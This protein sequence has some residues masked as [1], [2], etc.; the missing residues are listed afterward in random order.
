MVHS[1]ELSYPL[2]GPFPPSSQ[3]PT[4]AA[5]F[6]MDICCES[7]RSE[8]PRSVFREVAGKGTKISSQ[9]PG[10]SLC[11]LAKNTDSHQKNIQSGK[12]LSL[13]SPFRADSGAFN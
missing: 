6:I 8:P 7:H 12:K 9:L 11:Q 10:I 4:I 1:I 2:D 3:H 13:V 5:E